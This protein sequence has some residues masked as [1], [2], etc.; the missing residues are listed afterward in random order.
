MGTPKV[1]LLQEHI[2][3]IAF[4]LEIDSLSAMFDFSVVSWFRTKSRNAAVGGH[5]Q[6]K[7]LRGLAV[8]VVLNQGITKAAFIREANISGLTAIDEGDH[9]HVQVPK[10]S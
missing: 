10:S 4:C 8:D 5:P 9:I 3:F 1:D 2:T 7:H 6:S